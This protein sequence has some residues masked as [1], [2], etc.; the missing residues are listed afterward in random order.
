MPVYSVGRSSAAVVGASIFM[1]ARRSSLSGVASRFFAT[2]PE[3]LEALDKFGA[4]TF[5]RHP[6][7]DCRPEFP[8]CPILRACCTAYSSFWH[9]PATQRCPLLRRLVGAAQLRLLLLEPVASMRLSTFHRRC[10]VIERWL[11]IRQCSGEKS[12][13]CAL[14]RARKVRQRRALAS[15]CSAS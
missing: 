9:S 8:G 1:S 3:L 7:L 14:R 12:Q 2:H 11:T 6:R 13:L 10:G 5:D 4:G 15:H